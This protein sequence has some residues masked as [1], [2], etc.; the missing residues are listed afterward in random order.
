MLDALPPA[1]AANPMS[2]ALVAALVAAFMAALIAALVAAFLASVVLR[3]VLASVAWS[4][5]SCR[6]YIADIIVAKRRRRIG[7]LRMRWR[8]RQDSNLRPPGS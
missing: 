6:R 8:A 5:S 3:T 2:T 4:M 1:A 7:A